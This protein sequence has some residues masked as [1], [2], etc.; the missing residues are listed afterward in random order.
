[1]S[2]KKRILMLFSSPYNRPRG[3]TYTE[4]F[5][6]PEDMYTEKDVYKALLAN[7]YEVRLLGIHD[8]ISFLFKEI[9]ENPPDCIFNLVEVFNT[10]SRLEKNIAA[11]LEMLRIPFTGASSDNLHLCNNKALNRKLF[12]YHRIKIPHFYAFH[13]GRKV[14]LPKRLSLPCIIKPTT[15]EASRGI[16]QSSI[17][18]KEAAFI[19]R[20]RFIHD[21]MQLDAIAE[22]Y[23]EGREYYVTV[24]GHKQLTV[25]SARE[26]KFGELPEDARIA[27]YKAKWDDQYREKWG[28]KSVHAGK[29]AEGIWE[30]IEDVCK[31]AYR[32]LDMQSYLRLDIRVTSDG[33][34]YIIEPNANPCIAKID[35]VAMSAEKSGMNYNQL[36]KKIV[37][38]AFQNSEKG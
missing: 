27:T 11:V 33:K 38:L 22:E 18:D 31:R 7:G 1:M 14:W 35:E 30:E 32:A 36:I 12:S 5:A 10:E 15:E 17:V 24:M 6:D 3:Y 13:R 4:E 25:F 37:N 29:F 9:A 16:S 8:D 23:I 21:K 26:L 34:V 19:E 20:I 2:R 28:I